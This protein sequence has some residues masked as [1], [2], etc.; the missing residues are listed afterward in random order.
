MIGLSQLFCMEYFLVYTQ[1]LFM[2]LPLINIQCLTYF[3]AGP[4]MMI[5]LVVFSSWFFNSL[6]FLLGVGVLL[7]LASFLFLAVSIPLLSLLCLLLRHTIKV[8]PFKVSFNF[9]HWHNKLEQSQ[10]PISTTSLISKTDSYCKVL[11]SWHAL[12]IV[13]YFYSHL[14]KD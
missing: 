5:K 9:C 6:Y 7:V 1:R 3:L 13:D 14:D 8:V 2:I 11:N 4:L 12:A 10:S